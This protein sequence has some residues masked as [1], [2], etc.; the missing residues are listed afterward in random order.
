MRFFCPL[1][2]KIL[3]VILLGLIVSLPGFSQS[4]T[5]T[6]RKERAVYVFMLNKTPLSPGKMKSIMEFYPEVYQEIRKSRSN[7]SLS[8]GLGLIGGLMIGFPLGTALGGGDPVWAVAGAGVVLVGISIPLSLAAK[9]NAFRAVELYNRDKR[10]PQSS[11]FH[12]IRFGMNLH[13]IG[14]TIHL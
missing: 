8:N 11:V 7:A 6:V 12:E 5:L 9:K 13:G 3:S 10:N 4:D 2:F 1:S 14:L